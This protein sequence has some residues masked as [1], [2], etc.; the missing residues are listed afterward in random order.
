MGFKKLPPLNL[1]AYVSIEIE[2]ADQAKKSS[3]HKM[4][5]IA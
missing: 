5:V 1:R 3:T 2:E 4:L